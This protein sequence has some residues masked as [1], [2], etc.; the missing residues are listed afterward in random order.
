[1]GSEVMKKITDEQILGEKGVS[2]IQSLVLQMGFTWHPSN[3][4]LE[5][6]IDGWVELRDSA[7][8]EVANFWL[9]VQSRARSKVREDATTVKYTCTLKD[10][11]YWMQGN[12]NQPM[13]LVLSR[14]DDQ[15]AW[16]VSLRDYL[17][18]KDIK[19]E[20]MIVFDKTRDQLT[21]AT[22]EDW[23]SLGTLNGVGAFF[24]PSK[25]HESLASNL[26]E[27]TRF[28]PTIYSA[29]TTA[30]SGGELRERLRTIEQ[31]PAREWIFG[32]ERRIYSF[33]D[34]ASHPWNQVCDVTTIATTPTESLAFS[35]TDDDRFD[36]VRLLNQCLCAILGRLRMRYSKEQ[37][38]YYFAPNKPDP[39]RKLGYKSRKRRTARDVV[40]RHYSKR[41]TSRIAYY[42]HD[43]FTRRFLQFGDRWYLMVEPTYVF[44]TDGHEP[45]PYREER[46]SKIKSIEGD[47]AVAGKVAMFTDIL[48]D[49]DSLF[50]DPYPFIGFGTTESVTLD[51]G[52]DDDAWTRLKATAPE[53]NDSDDERSDFGA[54]LF[55]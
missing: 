25:R 28:N 38:C 42:R 47:A 46:L 44:T 33:H 8:G 1:M 35:D 54:G 52:I 34:L 14:P 13:I 10:V 55:D 18:G 22:A 26:V 23:K 39:V 31:W 45:D 43:A 21:A 7:T 17:Q 5:A 15:L 2:L 27:V 16:W 12:K 9:A 37:D 36:F 24:T 4:A 48:R 32:K 19:R 51:V 53:E 3:Q 29:V 6:G 41:D 30:K 20:R 11:E 50:D 40:R 49:H